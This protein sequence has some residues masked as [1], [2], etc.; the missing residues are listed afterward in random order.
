MQQIQGT[1]IPK[2]PFDFDK[3]LKFLGHF[4]PAMGEQKHRMAY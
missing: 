3:S 4:R 2:P 1:L